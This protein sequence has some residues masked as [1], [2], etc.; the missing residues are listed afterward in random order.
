VAAGAVQ[1]DGLDLCLREVSV[2]GVFR[3]ANT[4][5]AAIELLRRR[6]DA[7]PVFTRH[8]ISLEDL[9]DCLRTGAYRNHV[10]TLVTL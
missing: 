5:P 8:T 3:Y 2:Q 6:R 7:L 4:F 1:I 9:P 10:K